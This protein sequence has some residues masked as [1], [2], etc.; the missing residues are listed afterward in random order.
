MINSIRPLKPIED[1]RILIENV[2]CEGIIKKFYEKYNLILYKTADT[3][4]SLEFTK[5]VDS[6]KICV[7]EFSEIIFNHYLP[8]FLDNPKNNI[9][10]C[11]GMQCIGN[12]IY[13]FRKDHE[14][15]VPFNWIGYRLKKNISYTYQIV[16][17]VKIETKIEYKNNTGIY[18][19]THNPEKMYLLP[20][21]NV[22]LG[23]WHKKLLCIYNHT[24]MIMIYF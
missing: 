5:C 17:Y 23:E 16:F 22:K 18:I 6:I 13:Y 21:E 19:K 20:L 11:K 3:S 15:Y 9:L 10:I 14:N 8:L 7:S 12:D 1:C 4:K 24:M 2:N